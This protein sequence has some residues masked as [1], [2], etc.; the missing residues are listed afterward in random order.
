[1]KRRDFLAASCLAGVAPLAAA[2][3]GDAPAPG[4]KELFE[5][6]LYHVDAGPK[7][8]ALVDFFGKAAIPAWNRLGI[9]PVGVFS[10]LE[11]D[12]VGLYVVLPHKTPQSVLTATRQMMADEEVL[13]AGAAVLD[14]PFAEPAYQRVESSLMLAFDEC[15]KLEI[16][17]KKET[18]LFQLRTYESHSEAA[19]AKKVEM[20]TTLGELEI[21]R[22]TG[23]NPVFFG[24]TLVGR[25]LPNFVYMLT[26]ADRA[27]QQ[28]AWST[29]VADPAWQTLRGT[30]GYSDAEILSNLSSLVLRPAAFSQV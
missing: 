24:R 5:L 28:E 6:R 7:R 29:F 17:S 21:F 22:R 18:R 10:V 11:G 15:P 23:L 14:A 16:P 4:D 8:E 30:P 3:A 19:H 13:K 2:E 1:M 12:D 27:A 9:G 20:F 25:R 26:F